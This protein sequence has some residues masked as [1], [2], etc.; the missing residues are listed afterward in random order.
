MS[1]DSDPIKMIHLLLDSEVGN[2]L[3]SNERLNLN[4]CLQKTKSNNS[5]NDKELETIR[6]IF[7]KYKKYLI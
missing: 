6:R 1:T 5:L 3:E 2:Y 4:T 7:S